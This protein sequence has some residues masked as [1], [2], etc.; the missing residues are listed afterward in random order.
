MALIIDNDTALDAKKL[1]L[2][3]QAIAYAERGWAVFPIHGV[4]EEAGQFIC[5]CPKKAA[6]PKKSTGKHPLT[7]RGFLDATTNL[8]TIKAWWGNSPNANIAMATGEKSGVLVVDIDGPLGAASLAGKEM[9]N[10]LKA[11]TGRADGGIHYYFQ[12]PGFKVKSS[13]N[14]FPGIDIRADGGY[15]ILPGSRHESGN[16]YKWMAEPEPAP[17]PQWVLDKILEK[18]Q[19]PTHRAA[20]KSVA[21]G[22]RNDYLAGYTGKLRMMD[23]MSI[24]QIRAATHVANT[25]DL[26]EP[27]PR[28]E[29][30][31]IVDSITKHAP[32]NRLL[33]FPRTDLGTGESFAYLWRDRV[34]WLPSTKKWIVHS[35]GVWAPDSM[36]EANRL[37]KETARQTQI[38]AASLDVGTPGRDTAM[39]WAERMES[40]KAQREMLEAAKTELAISEDQFDRYPELLNVANGVVNLR[41]GERLPHRPDYY[42]RQQGPVAYDPNAKDEQW[43]RALDHAT[44]HNIELQRFLQDSIGYSAI[45]GTTEE[46]VFAVIGRAGS[47]KGTT[48]GPVVAALGNYAH[49]ASAESFLVTRNGS[50]GSGATEDI[51]RLMTARLVVASEPDKGKQLRNGLLKW[52]SGGDTIVARSLYQE[53]REYKPQFTIWFQANE[54]PETDADD[55]GLWR[56]LKRITMDNVVPEGERD[57]SLKKWLEDPL[58][59]GPA[60]LAWIVQG[61][62][63]YLAKGRLEVPQIVRADTEALKAAN[64]PVQEFL[65]DECELGEDFSAPVSELWSRFES[66]QHEAGDG[67]AYLSKPKFGQRLED[68]GFTKIRGTGGKWVRTGLRVWPAEGQG[69][70]FSKN[71][72]ANIP[73]GSRF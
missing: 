20:P 15:A 2:Q 11:S 39:E 40:G 26:V 66:W 35:G 5:D 44:G 43:Q 25:E 42:L 38:A 37:A 12:W 48:L 30:D 16:F 27:L 31:K 68:R 22:G 18:A 36:L 41:T 62:M 28:D 34:R 60:V 13:T 72:L 63:S 21:E 6:C 53:S 8:T 32:R 61:A 9:P 51:A 24:E 59:G 71:Q 4:H 73:V 64:D 33:T 67:Y 7:P 23:I 55:T 65:Q 19:T 70:V 56:R 1:T 49:T 50:G 45:G 17:I 10:T 3:E 47:G 54:W 57:T 29:V 58:G 52:L 46:S 14:L 69:Q